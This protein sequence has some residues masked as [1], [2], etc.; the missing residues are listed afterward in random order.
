[1]AKRGNG[2]GNIRRRPDGLWEA[3]LIAEVDSQG[4][5]RR[6]SLYGK[7][8]K[9]ATIKLREAQRRAVAGERVGDH[10]DTVGAF[11]ERWLTE[12][13]R[14][15]AQTN[16]RGVT[17]IWLGATSSRRWAI[18][19]WRCSHLPMFNDGSTL[20]APK[21]SP[22]TVQLCHAVLR[23]ALGQAVRWGEARGNVASLARSRG[24][25]PA[26]FFSEPRRQDHGGRSPCRNPA[27]VS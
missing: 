24:P 13:C 10:T 5:P 1:M 21:G 22:R 20:T 16:D 27:S 11:L 9:E 2:E 3:R 15:R 18:T 25:R 19:R 14:P 7:T 12:D 23:R 26:G 6:R 17:P 4:R 8:R